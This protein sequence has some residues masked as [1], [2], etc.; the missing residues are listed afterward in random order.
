G[1]LGLLCFLGFAVGPRGLAVL[2]GVRLGNDG[3]LLGLRGLSRV[4]RESGGRNRQGENKAGQQVALHH[5]SLLSAVNSAYAELTGAVRSHSKAGSEPNSHRPDLTQQ[6]ETQCVT[7][8]RPLRGGL[9]GGGRSRAAP[10][11]R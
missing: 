2:R 10:S 8:R 11:S 6:N 4:R 1:A 5:C 7:R 3:V 9:L